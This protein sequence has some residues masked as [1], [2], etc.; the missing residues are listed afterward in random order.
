M[1]IQPPRAH[2]LENNCIASSFDVLLAMVTQVIDRDQVA[3]LL[4]DGNETVGVSPVWVFGL[5]GKSSALDTDRANNRPDVN[6]KKIGGLG[7]PQLLL[8]PGGLTTSGLT[9]DFLPVTP[10]GR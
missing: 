7:K 2:I 3:E 10:H 4:G 1:A 5:V 8:R 9:E 6:F